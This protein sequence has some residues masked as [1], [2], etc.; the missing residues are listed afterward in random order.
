MKSKKI[1][2]PLTIVSELLKYRLFYN[3]ALVRW[4]M[5][6]EDVLKGYWLN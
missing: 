4:N 1:K 3:P 2:I 5:G 6:G